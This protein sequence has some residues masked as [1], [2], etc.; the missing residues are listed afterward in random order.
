AI[1]FGSVTHRQ[2]FLEEP[3]T[4]PVLNV[5]LPLVAFFVIAPFLFLVFHAYFLLNLSMLADDARRFGAVVRNRTR[6]DKSEDIERHLRQQLPNFIFLR[7]L[8]GP[9]GQGTGATDW[10]LVAIAWLTVVIGPVLLLLFAQLQFLPYHD[11]LATW[12]QRGIFVAAVGLLWWFWP[13]I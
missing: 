11:E 10:L 1:A 12:T 9:R 7:M 3:V 4:L 8:G 6:D 13:R 5:E 2:L